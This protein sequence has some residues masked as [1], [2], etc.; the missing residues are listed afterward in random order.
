M[1]DKPFKERSPEELAEMERR[2]EQV[3]RD[4]RR[5]YGP[6]KKHK[7][8]LESAHIVTL[9]EVIE[10]KLGKLAEIVTGD[11]PEL[12]TALAGEYLDS[13]VLQIQIVRSKLDGVDTWDDALQREVD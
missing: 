9:S 10:E 1:T 4:R 7:T 8:G 2:L 6:P 13:F 5:D 12:V 11:E 3:R